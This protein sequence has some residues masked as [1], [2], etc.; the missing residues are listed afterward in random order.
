MYF[1]LCLTYLFYNNIAGRET[2]AIGAKE[3]LDITTPVPQ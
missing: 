1:S 2:V 3:L